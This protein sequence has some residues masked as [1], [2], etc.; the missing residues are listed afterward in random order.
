MKTVTLLRF[1]HR[2]TLFLLLL[3]MAPAVGLAQDVQLGEVSFLGL[4][5]DFAG[6]ELS[7]RKAD[8]T[9]SGTGQKAL[10]IYL[11]GGSSCGSDNAIHIIKRNA[12]C[13]TSDPR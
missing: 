3:L 13:A 10:V 2:N 1:I 6:I 4:Q 12:K 9:G 5:R 11:H 8:I 7:Y